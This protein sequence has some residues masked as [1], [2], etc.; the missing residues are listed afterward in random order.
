MS[1]GHDG[2]AEPVSLE[3]VMV[4]RGSYGGGP[5]GGAGLLW[6]VGGETI[7][8]GRHSCGGRAKHD[9]IVRCREFESRSPSPKGR[10]GGTGILE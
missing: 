9:R 1:G 8:L 2:E 10:D 3:G 4:G 7:M 6:R 5:D